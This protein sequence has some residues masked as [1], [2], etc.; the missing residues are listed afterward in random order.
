MSKT[1]T[2]F[3]PYRIMGRRPVGVIEY[4]S[5]ELRVTVYKSVF[6]MPGDLRH[7]YWCQRIAHHMSQSRFNNK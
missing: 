6:A 4:D 1:H 3:V 5:G 7:K 2:I